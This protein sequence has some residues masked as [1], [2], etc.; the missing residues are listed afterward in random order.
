MKKRISILSILLL[1]FLMISSSFAA[2][3]NT[4]LEIAENNICEINLSDYGKLEKK[5]VASNLEKKEV[6]LELKVT[7]TSKLEEG[8]IPAEVF[9][10]IDNSYSM[11]EEISAGVTRADALLESAQTLAENLLTLNKNIQIGVVSFSTSADNEGTLED[12]KL[13]SSLSN[14]LATVKDAISKIKVDVTGARTNIEAGLTIASENFSNN[15]D[16]NKYI[17]L[18][19]DGVPNTAVGGPTLTYSGE[20]TT[21]TK[22]KLQEIN[23]NG[24]NIMSV[25]T[26]VDSEAKP[27]PEK[28]YKQLAEDIFGTP[29]K[30]TAGLF[31]YI[32]DDSLEKTI[33]ETIYSEI[34]KVIEYKIEKLIITD[35]FPQEIIDNYNFE[36][37]SKSNI[38]KITSTVDPTTNSI[39][40]TIEVLN[41]GETASVQYKLT[42][43]ENYNQQII[44]KIIPTNTKLE[45][46]YTIKDESV[47]SSSTISP[48]L[49]V[50]TNAIDNTIANTDIPKAG[51]NS[52]PLFIAITILFV[53]L[54]FAIV[55]RS[56]TKLN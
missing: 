8:E 27:I 2:T 53:L 15:Q 12:A 11:T 35:Y 36:Y 43:K 38:G 34:A 51:N 7:N 3:T 31:F 1:S 22:A 23:Q 29:E 25:M 6:T 30:P 39:T 10:V 50:K 46:N 26:G 49:V 54:G 32:S 41:E 33:E 4:T 37:V 28:T 45:A 18:L 55:Y 14:N 44:D 5:I 9:L 13:R 20:V 42:L 19:T 21:K 52:D 56:K 17:I 24:I 40:W 47:N 16:T 48:K